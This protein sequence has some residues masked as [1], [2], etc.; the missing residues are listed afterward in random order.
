MENMVLLNDLLYRY[1]SL[2][3]CRDDIEKAYFALISCYEK[4]AKVLLCGNGGSAADCDHIVGELMKG[5][6]KKRK[7]SGAIRDTLLASGDKKGEFLS[8][9]LQGSLP[10]ISLASASALC[11]AF[12]NDVS[13]DL[14][15]AQQVFGYGKKDDILIGLS[16][17]GNS[18]NVVYALFLAKT[19]GMIT[20]G[21][22]GQ[23][24]GEM[25]DICDIMIRVPKTATPEAQ[26][27][28]LPIYHTLCAMVEQYFFDR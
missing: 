15:F 26:E 16:T 11:T 10:A 3:E 8:D 2:Q 19:M 4:N 27:L 9:H 28:H 25:K 1:P 13:N 6:L 5:F 18:K 21:L 22:S 12:S 20:I 24:G 14:V 17:S 23:S 7:I